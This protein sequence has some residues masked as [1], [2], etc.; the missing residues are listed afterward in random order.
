MLS[1]I[2]LHGKL[3]KFIGYKEFDVKVFRTK[4]R[5]I[6]SGKV[7]MRLGMFYAFILCLL[8]FT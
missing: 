7:S 6:A 4:N 8:F 5:P 2:K 3:A 1:K